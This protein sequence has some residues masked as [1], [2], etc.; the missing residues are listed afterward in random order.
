MRRDFGNKNKKPN[1]KHF[2]KAN[3]KST[4]NNTVEAL[5]EIK[6]NTNSNQLFDVYRD[7]INRETLIKANGPEIHKKI[8]QLISS[9]GLLRMSSIANEII[10]S[11]STC[12]IY[13]NEIKNFLEKRRLVEFSV[14]NNDKVNFSR[15]L[16]SIFIDSGWSLWLLENKI[17]GAQHWLGVDSKRELIREIRELTNNNFIMDILVVYIGK[18]VETTTIP[19]YLQGDLAKVLNSADLKFLNDYLRIK[20]FDSNNMTVDMIPLLL[21][22][23]YKSNVIDLY[24]SLITSL[25]CIIGDEKALQKLKNNLIKPISVLYKAVKDERLLPVLIAFGI[26]VELNSENNNAREKII[27]EYTA[28]N[29]QEVIKL[30]A[31]YFDKYEN[32]A[33]MAVLFI[34]LKSEA[35]IGKAN[36]YVGILATIADDIRKVLK[37]DDDSYAAALALNSLNDRYM[38]H[39]WSIYIRFA[40][41]NELSVQDFNTDLD[42]LRKLYTLETKLSP[43]SFLLSN[44]KTYIKKSLENISANIY[45]LTKQVIKLATHGEVNDVSACSQISQERYLKYLARYYLVNRQYDKAIDT[46]KNALCHTNGSDTLKCNAALIVAYL[47]SKDYKSA[48]NLLVDTY[49]DW[50]STP[51]TLPFDEIIKEIDDPENWPSSIT[52]PITL[53]LYT[54]FVNNNNIAHLRYSFERFNLENNIANPYDFLNFLHNIRIEYAK[55]YLKLVWRPEIM[56]QTLLY[57]G[58][59]EIE[60]ARIQVCKVLVEIDSENAS[61]YQTEIRERVKNLELAKVTKLVDQSR[62]YVD[63]SA[64]KKSLKSR[65]GDVYSKY[66]NGMLNEDIHESDVIDTL[67]DIFQNL[68]GPNTSLTSLMSRFHLVGE[69]DLQFAAIFSEIANEFLLGEHGLNAYLSTR[70]R[71]GKFSNAIRK[72]ITDE[73]LITELSEETGKYSENS[74]WEKELSNLEETEKENVLLLLESFGKRIDDIILHVRDEL[75]QVTIQDDLNGG[76][77]NRY[78]LFVYRTSSVERMYAKAKLSSLNNIDEFI[79]F[80]IDIL[81]QKT[82]DNLVLVK[83]RI[84]G[85]IKSSILLSFDK[86]NES[87]GSLKC[88]SRLGELHNHIARAKTNI[89]HQIMNVSTWFTRSEVYDRP[90]YTTDFPILIAKSMVSNLYSGADSWSGI[91]IASSDTTGLMPGRTLDGM[92][93]IYC[94]LFENA[95]EHSGLPISDLLINVQASYRDGHFHVSITNSLNTDELTDENKAKIELISNEIKKKDTRVKAQKERGSGFHKMWSTINS[96]LYKDPKLEFSYVNKNEFLVN[97]QFNIESVD[98]QNTNY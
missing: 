24:E 16:D 48:I 61:D 92:V 15:I 71:H 3:L 70:V 53:A 55:L 58:S 72:P 63:V 79:D 91:N 46:L 38:N 88:G 37:F 25:R 33:D 41:M 96:P 59:K 40:V 49:L 1:D 36:S 19:G 5:N 97:I 4:K 69:E 18:R 65:L 89:Q 51:T 34:G 60:E 30:T 57:N 56:G 11:I 62:V 26:N 42:Y 64:I 28:G 82:D 27:E 95:I 93:D 77:K 10:W 90:D 39:T 67:T 80:C 6:S 52:L 74:F 43:F 98:E 17:A 8:E 22:L 84:L 66:R 73:G 7:L 75:I 83:Q 86:L 21:T 87:L 68:E 12:L 54:N 45:P 78:A 44:D 81:W 29:Y 23:D 31:Y 32:K 14:V 13:K 50:N 47:R 20:L 9:D 94:A 2:L 76:N 35:K 85:D